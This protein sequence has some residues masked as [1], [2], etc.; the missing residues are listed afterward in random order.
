MKAVVYERYGGPECLRVTKVEKPVPG[1]DEV[2]VRV[3]AVSINDWDLALLSGSPYVNRVING[4]FRPKKVTILGSDIAGQVEAV[5]KNVT[6]FAVGDAVF[7]DL[8]ENGWGGFA[9]YATARED[10]LEAMP[11]NLTFKEAA[12]IPQAGLLAYQGLHYKDRTIR[13][14]ERVL[15]NGASGGVGPIAVQL[16]R[17]AGA[18]VTGVCRGEKAEF[19]RSFGADRVIDYRQED[20]TKTGETYDMI[21]DV[22]GFHSLP[23][24]RRALAPGGLYA[25]LGGG[26][27][28]ILQVMFG[29]PVVSLFGSRTM[30]MVFYRA[31]K[32][33]TELKTLLESG[34]V[35][36][37]V[38]RVFP[39]EQA[40]EAMRYYA[41]G[42]ARGKV[43]IAVH[44]AEVKPL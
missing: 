11:K 5:G 36:P 10:A 26:G 8:C 43:V 1:D 32:G 15:V 29:G 33:L 17:L 30:G 39:L 12:S 34:R 35:V 3:H 4:L 38:E 27:R 42:H 44:D 6:R 23:D 20:F 13:P 31:N 25:M 41:E 22:K 14:G 7:G 2:L 9:E 19:V 37:V 16:A 40:A 28:S 24:Y 21:L 18:E